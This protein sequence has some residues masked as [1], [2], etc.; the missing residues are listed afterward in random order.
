MTM[1]SV[2]TSDIIVIGSFVIEQVE[3]NTDIIVIGSFVI[4]QVEV[5]TDIIVLP[6]PV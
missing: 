3:V 4:K 5:N 1:V 2:F 6:L